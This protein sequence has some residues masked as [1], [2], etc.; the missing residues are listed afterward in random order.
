VSTCIHCF[1]HCS[2]VQSNAGQCK[3]PVFGQFSR[4]LVTA[5]LCVRNHYRLTRSFYDFLSSSRP[6]IMISP[7]F[8]LSVCLPVCLS[9]CFTVFARCLKMACFVSI[10]IEST[11]TKYKNNVIIN[12]T[13]LRTEFIQN[14]STGKHSENVFYLEPTFVKLYLKNKTTVSTS[15]QW[16]QDFQSSRCDSD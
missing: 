8:S 7:P 12:L 4:S 1:I 13:K 6:D 5:S 3:A 11:L 9:I 14:Q 16:H 15:L 10:F 2:P